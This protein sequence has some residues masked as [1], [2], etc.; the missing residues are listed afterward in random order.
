ME[1]KTFNRLTGSSVTTWDA[2]WVNLRIQDSIELPQ[3]VSDTT[4]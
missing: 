2:M 4:P 1:A 3:H